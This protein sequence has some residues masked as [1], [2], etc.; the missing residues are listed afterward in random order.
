MAEKTAFTPE[1]WNNLL[2]APLIAALAVTAADPSGLWG[3]LRENFASARVLMETKHTTTS[4]LI[5]EIIADLETAEGRAAA[6]AAIEARLKDAKPGEIKTRTIEMLKSIGSSVEA[7][8]PASAPALK[9]WLRT[10]ATRVAEASKEGGFFG[11]GGVAVSEP[12][13]LTLSEIDAALGLH[14]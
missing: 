11:I 12:E 7:K 6:R 1:E 13:K 8:S 5:K 14:A 9:D 2:A 3:L 4:A 10:I